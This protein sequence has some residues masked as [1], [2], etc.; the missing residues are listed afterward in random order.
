[1]SDFEILII[2]IYLHFR[3]ACI[4]TWI[5]L[6]KATTTTTPANNNNNNNNSNNNNNTNNSDNNNNNNNNNNDNNY[7]YISNKNCLETFTCSILST[8]FEEIYFK[9]KSI[10][11]VMMGNDQLLEI[12]LLENWFF[13]L[14]LK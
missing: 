6:C 9:I 10:Q 8:F 13:S 14:I 5:P 4:K 3:T 12:H 1:M 2:L 7:N 11:V